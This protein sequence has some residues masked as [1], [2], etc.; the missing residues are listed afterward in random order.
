MKIRALVLDLI[1]NISVLKELI[2]YQVLDP[3][4]WLWSKQ[5]RYY[6]KGDLCVVRMSDAE[7]KYT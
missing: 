2:Q 3:A 7:F 1:H 5:L 6:L 4:N